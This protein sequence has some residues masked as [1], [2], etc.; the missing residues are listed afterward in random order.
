V[1]SHITEVNDKGHVYK[2]LVFWCPGCEYA[3]S[4]GELFGGAHL[5]PISGD[6]NGRPIWKFSGTTEAPTLSPSILSLG[7]P[8]G[9][10]H[11]F[12]NNGVF[13]FLDDCEHKLKGMYVPLP[14]M[15][16]WLE[17]V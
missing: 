13:Q 16:E 10:C 15:P 8:N 11:S 3:D 9:K 2:A 6:S 7:S 1:K 4:D 12:L 14:D 5:L 17:K